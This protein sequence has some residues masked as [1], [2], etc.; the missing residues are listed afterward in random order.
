MKLGERLRES[1]QRQNLTIDDIAGLSGLSK[2]YI[3]QVET[4]KASPSIPSLEKLAKAL[5]VPMASLFAAETD[6]FTT[7]FIPKSERQVLM[8]GSPDGPTTER[9]L[10]H[11]LSE[12]GRDLEFCM[13]ELSPGY[14]AGD[15]EHRHEGEEVFY[16]VKGTIKVIHGGEEFEL[17]EGDSIHV[18]ATIVHRIENI[19]NKNAEIMVSRT[20]S[21]FSDIRIDRTEGEA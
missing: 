4:G 7:R 12:S 2:P 14:V 13:L 3:S 1:R 11:F 15:A 6:P 20:P 18:N 8:F 9:K 16:V 19:G 17:N 21:G 10:I 5:E